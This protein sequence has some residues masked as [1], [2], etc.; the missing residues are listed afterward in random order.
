MLGWRRLVWVRRHGKF[1]WFGWFRRWRSVLKLKPRDLWYMIGYALG[2]GYI[3]A[4]GDAFYLMSTDKRIMKL[5]ARKLGERVSSRVTAT[6][7]KPYLKD[8]HTTRVRSKRFTDQL[9][10]RGF[11]TNKSHTDGW[12]VVP[13][14]GYESQFLRGLMDSDGCVSATKKSKNLQ[15]EFLSSSKDM[16]EWSRDHLKDE[17]GIEG[18]VYWKGSV[19]SLRYGH[20]DSHRLVFYLYYGPGLYNKRK[21]DKAV[22]LIRVYPVRRSPSR[23][24]SRIDWPATWKEW[25]YFLKDSTSYREVAKKMGVRPG[26]LSSHLSKDKALKGRIKARLI[27]NREL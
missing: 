9:Q 11:P 10:K 3:T 22:R 27:K 21:R 17:L 1:L 23:R 18:R 20:W 6:K 25:Q 15:S 19:W 13:G 14:Y 4:R 24:L 16:L 8:M 12:L 7:E 5:C 26:T 2:D